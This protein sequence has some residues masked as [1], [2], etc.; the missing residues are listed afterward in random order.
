MDF[1]VKR[2]IG[3]SLSQEYDS[4]LSKA[5]L[6]CLGSA[7]LALPSCYFSSSPVG[8]VTHRLLNLL[9][10]QRHSS[11]CTELLHPGPNA[12]PSTSYG[13]YDYQNT[14]GLAN[15]TFNWESFL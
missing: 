14:Q 9:G 7:N 11:I 1:D 6:V 4:R 3:F 15:Q 13:S 8:L 10:E 2:M 12:D 5:E